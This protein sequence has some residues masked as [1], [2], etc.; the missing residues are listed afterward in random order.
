MEPV[1]A[2]VMTGREFKCPSYH[3][4][5]PLLPPPP[6]FTLAVLVAVDAADDDAASTS[7]AIDAA[8]LL[9]TASALLGIIAMVFSLRD[10][11]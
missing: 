8:N 11:T 1:T 9:W 3:W 5:N 7:L 4:T 6:S 10:A 2:F